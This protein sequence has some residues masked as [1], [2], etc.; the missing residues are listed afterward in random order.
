MRDISKYIRRLEESLNGIKVLMNNPILMNSFITEH[1]YDEITKQIMKKVNAR[2]LD[3]EVYEMK[4]KLE[5]ITMLQMYH[6]NITTISH[7]SS[8][9]LV[10][11]LESMD[12]FLSNYSKVIDQ[13]IS[14]WISIQDVAISEITFREMRKEY[15]ELY[16]FKR[17]QQEIINNL[18]KFDQNFFLLTNLVYSR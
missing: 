2:D 17:F 6:R 4:N 13:K 9:H 12:I 18:S 8:S 3:S 15:Q 14:E 1:N 7:Y 11:E 10:E 16:I 5:I